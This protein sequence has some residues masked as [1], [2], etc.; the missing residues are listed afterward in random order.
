MRS[1]M[2]R[3]REVR[4]ALHRP[5]ER[6]TPKKISASIDTRPALYN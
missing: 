6:A 1:H 5:C 4:Y 3:Q 2:Q